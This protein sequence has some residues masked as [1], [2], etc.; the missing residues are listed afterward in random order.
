[1]IKREGELNK[2]RT[3]IAAIVIGLI[4]L[5]ALLLLLYNRYQLKHLANAKLFNA[6]ELIRSKNNQITD[7]INYAS[8]IQ[9]SMLP[10]KEDITSHLPALF[11]FF[12]PR[13][14]VSGDFYW[15]AARKNKLFLVLADCTGHGVPGAFMSIIGH[16]LLNEI[17]NEMQISNAGE[18][19][20]LL[21]EK[22]VH[23]LHQEENNAGGQTGLQKQDDGMD[24][25]VC[26]LDTAT[27]EIEFAGANQDLFLVNKAVSEG[28]QGT[29]EKVKGDIYSIGGMF[30]WEEVKFTSHHKKLKKGTCIYL[31]SDGYYDQ[32]G[33]ADNKKFMLSRFEEILLNMS[34]INIEKQEEEL[35]DKFDSWKGNKKQIDDVLVIGFQV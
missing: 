23:M 31:S 2:Q 5:C 34:K 9:E 16:S 21:H 10:R 12:R 4:L 15:F 32:F 33:G 3:I 22:V 24:I 30:E 19:L 17:I 11:I 1:M 28:R 7:S 20:T 13:D 25:S 18:I 14:I 6:Y 35:A 26:I 27:N 8:R 29:I